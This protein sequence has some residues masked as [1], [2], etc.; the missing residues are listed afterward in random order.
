MNFRS[1]FSV[2][3][4]LLFILAAAQLAAQ[5]ELAS[6]GLNAPRDLAGEIQE[7]VS[8]DFKNID[9]REVCDYIAMSA[10]KNIIIDRDV[11]GTVSMRL[12]G[13]YWLDALK[14]VADQVDSVVLDEGGGVY[15]VAKPPR[16]TI[17]FTEAP[18]RTA[19]ATIAK[20]SGANVIIQP[21][22]DALITARLNNVPWNEALRIIAE[23]AG[24]VL[25]K[26]DYDV[27]RIVT[28]E[29]LKKQ[30]VIKVIPLKYL[31]PPDAYIAKIESQFLSGGPEQEEA[32][33]A[34]RVTGVGGAQQGSE[35]SG[36]VLTRFSLL[37]VLRSVLSESGSVQ[38]DRHSNSL[39]VKDIKPKIRAVEEM[40]RL[41]DR[42]PYQV[43]VDV[44]FVTTT[45]LDLLRFGTDWGEE[46][47]RVRGS[48]SS[49]LI[50]FPF[51]RGAGGWEDGM[52][53]TPNGPNAA[54]VDSVEND[55]FD[56]GI[57]DFST[58]T[59]TLQMLK[60]DNR[61]RVKQAPRLV[62]L[63]NTDATIFVGETIRFA[64]TFS[65]TA[66]A[67][68]AL[69]GI[70]EAA[71]S[72]VEVGFQLLIIPHCIRGSDRVIV[73]LIPQDETLSG[74]DEQGFDVF[75]SAEETIRLPRVRSRTVVTKMLLKSGDTAVIGGL[76]EEN[77][78]EN[79]SKWPFLGDIPIIGWL[80]KLKNREGRYNNLVIFV[81]I[82]VM[83][84]SE[85]DRK[86]YRRYQ[87]YDW[88]LDMPGSEF[89][90]PVDSDYLRRR[91]ELKM[92]KEGYDYGVTEEEIFEPLIY[93]EEKP[94]AQPPGEE[95]IES[96]GEPEVEA[97]E[98]PLLIEE[99][100]IVIEEEKK[101]V[102]QGETIEQEKKAPET[103]EKQ[104]KPAEEEGEPEPEE[105]AE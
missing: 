86:I 33:T 67:G 1:G 50:T 73:T 22:I 81:T 30:L 60:R 52:T 16:I 103:Q 78:L 63:D 105:G 51:T 35:T 54:Q 92:R 45:N 77:A 72:P 76:F 36:S 10:D 101:T 70:R 40:V 90:G 84:S 69:T 89:G 28:S 56:F 37:E 27:Y 71:N 64:E 18:M 85:D 87:K 19:V 32:E 82:F 98:E 8:F 42:E 53:V 43:L 47:P 12:K 34:L 21:E 38:Y 31:Q 58:L 95:E 23:T 102:E 44:K 25:V 57:M 14:Q 80:F 93:R 75:T 97:E 7:T 83:K 91:P 20:L 100:P 2:L 61:S 94:E 26:E 29:S 65:A 24:F 15:K 74:E 13:V 11:E 59:A 9:I 3:L 17:T 55:V 68:Q 104:E 41:L 5:D 6:T 46:G 79:T 88:D 62:T 39:I 4:V 49:A 99:E 66:Q 96:P 48:G